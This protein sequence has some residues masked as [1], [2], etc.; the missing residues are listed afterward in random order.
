MK[1]LMVTVVVALTAGLAAAQG[2]D[3][4]ALYEQQCTKCHGADGK[5]DTKMG[6]KAGAKDYT[7]PKVQAELKDDKAFKS[8]KEGLKDGDKV[9]MKPAEKVTDEEIKA[10][11]A[12]MRTFKKG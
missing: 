10:L 8:I 9:L 6:K 3:T 1:K 2:A 4:K 12:Y 7:D 5:G 11:I